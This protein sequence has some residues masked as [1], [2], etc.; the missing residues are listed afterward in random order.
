M[1]LKGNDGK[2]KSGREIKIRAKVLLSRKYLGMQ[3]KLKE[4]DV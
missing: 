1:Q 3:E 2:P 4:K